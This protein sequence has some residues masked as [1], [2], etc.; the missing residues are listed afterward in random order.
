[1]RKWG[2]EIIVFTAGFVI[3]AFE[4]AGSRIL[5]PY[6]GTSVFVWSSLIGLVMGALSLG[7]A[8][9]GRLSVK[10]TDMK[11][12]AWILS[13]AAIFIILTATGN[14]KVM[15]KLKWLISDF[16]WLS[17]IATTLLFT[18]ASFFLG[19][20]LPY[21]A[22]L[23]IPEIGS[24]GAAV[25]NIYA[26]S[27]IGSIAGTF[28]G[29]F[30]LIPLVGF[31]SLMIFLALILLLMA[32][33]LM[34]AEKGYLIASMPFVIAII[35]FLFLWDKGKEKDYL[36]RDTAYNRVIVYDS[37]DE[38]S[39]RP[40][41]IL[42]VND[43]TSSAMYLDGKGLV[44]EVLKYYR[45]AGHFNPDFE[46]ALMIGG[47]GYAF[48]NDFIGKY[49]HATLDVVEIDPGLT[50][51]ARKYFGLKDHPRMN[52]FHQDGRIYLN[53]TKKKYDVI[54]MDAYKSLLTIPY[55]LTTLEAVREMHDRLTT[56]GV[57]LANVISTMDPSNNYFLRAELATYREVFPR[58]LLFAVRDPE[59]TELLQN[60]MIVGLKSS[61]KV[62][63]ESDDPEL[64]KYLSHIVTLDIPSD[65]P[66]LTDEYAPV[67]FYTNKLLKDL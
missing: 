18:P 1:M 56:D 46:N 37:E 21:T 67:D 66:V 13:F 60:F 28:A 61:L 41:R 8:V 35:A 12:L 22:R 48:P 54:Y 57:V 49:P 53:R 43:E 65:L 62:P 10:A 24:S 14:D 4:L 27:T 16:R 6:V 63:L 26:A 64:Q 47:S 59:D 20:V 33:V 17:L 11:T 9:G 30:L 19:M 36:D 42:K 5:G 32:I 52:I 51:I 7:Y 29:G 39:G 55:Q 58:V 50:R 3:M 15:K 2:P 44:F 40:V 38:K 25:G 23:K 31:K 34:L 45:L